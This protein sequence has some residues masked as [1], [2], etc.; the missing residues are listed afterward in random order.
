M[1]K[2]PVELREKERDIYGRGGAARRRGKGRQRRR[3]GRRRGDQG[4]RRRTRV[5]TRRDKSISV[6]L[7]PAELF[8]SVHFPKPVDSAESEG[9]VPKWPPD[10][11]GPRRAG[12]KTKPRLSKPPERTGEWTHCGQEYPSGDR[13]W[14]SWIGDHRV[15]EC[16]CSC[17]P[18]RY[19]IE[20]FQ[21]K[22]RGTRSRGGGV[23]PAPCGII[24]AHLRRLDA[25]P[26]TACRRLRAPASAGNP[27]FCPACRLRWSAGSQG[28][29]Y[30]SHC[31][32][33]G[34]SA[35]RE[36]RL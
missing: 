20:K 31:V 21:L 8:R 14:R 13:L 28:G 3:F 34:V 23:L 11:D 29:S 22:D 16:P 4:G 15:D 19:R 1:W 5:H 6:S 33:P 12:G 35:V 26:S 30:A 18:I 2:P 17:H 7:R 10:G 32:S 27:G 36:R 25:P 9:R 24:P